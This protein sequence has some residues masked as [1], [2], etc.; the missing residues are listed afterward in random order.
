MKH[1]FEISRWATYLR[2]HESIS[3]NIISKY[4][5]LKHLWVHIK[6]LKDANCLINADCKTT[7][8]SKKIKTTVETLLCKKLDVLYSE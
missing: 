1:Y 2:V 3:H 8:N 6:C 7:D 5:T 4:Y